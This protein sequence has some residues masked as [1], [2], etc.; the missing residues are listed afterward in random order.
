MIEEASKK[1]STGDY[2]ENVR[3]LKEAS[4]TD[5]TNPRVW[6]KLCQGYQFT[7]QF[8]L[9][10]A[11]C[12]RQIE[13]T[14]DFTYYNSLGLAYM[15]KK[16]YADAVSAFEKAVDPQ[17]PG[18]NRDL[19]WALL[20]AQ[21]YERALPETQRLV[22]GG[23]GDPSERIF[24]LETLGAIYA[25][26]GQTKKAQ[27]VFAKIPKTDSGQNVKTCELKTDTQGDLRVV[28]TFSQ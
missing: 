2:K 28:C 26:L 25:K 17:N 5:P 1:F 20:G 7:E 9:A 19:V 10:I 21:Q 3:L 16:D 4:N 22:E 15:A 23:G 12:K 11:A 8:D 13:I 18:P 27:E 24:G 6:W 14:G